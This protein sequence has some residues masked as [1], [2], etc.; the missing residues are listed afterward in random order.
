M[1]GLKVVFAGAMAAA[2]MGMTISVPASAHHSATA[3]Y[4]VDKT[5]Q[6]EGTVVQFLIRNPHSS[7]HVAATDKSG[8]II[9]WAIE[10]G[11]SGALTNDNIKADTL[12]P[13][14]KVVVIGNPARD[15]SA[16]R[17]LMVS[18]ERPADGWKWA[19]TFG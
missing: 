18:I 5:V 14:D 16:H 6:I 8:K 15:P 12:K 9:T 7:L 19:G 2:M 1:N 17:L 13:G 4:V 10:W 11:A 3:T